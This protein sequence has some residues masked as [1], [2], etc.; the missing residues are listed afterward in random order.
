[1][2]RY[3]AF[4]EYEREM[5]SSHRAAS[6]DQGLTRLTAY[7]TNALLDAVGARRGVALLDVGTG[8]GLV[9]EGAAIRGCAVSGI[10]I[11][12]QMLDIARERVPDAEFREGSAEELPFS[13]ASFDAVV[14]N[15]V[16]LHL[17]YPDRLAFET[18]RVLRPGGRA[19]FTV[20]GEGN[21]NR[22]LGVFP[23]ALTRS[24]VAPPNDIPEGPLST[25]YANH[26]RF[27]DLLRNGGLS[28]V[29]VSDIE[30][31]FTVDPKRWWDDTVASTPRTGGLVSRQLPEVR[32]QLRLTYE[33]I[34][35]PYVGDDGLATFPV[36]AVLARGVR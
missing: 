14:G 11:S 7:T 31:T 21:R 2:S 9:A 5:W 3:D 16:V 10:D 19:A 36:V 30:W 20:W 32:E 4:N 34:V 15:F 23:D 28:E 17:G 27:A 6:Y 35:A 13:D 25:D 18:S 12:P 26:D 29:T 24:A 22:V 8:P 33:S 1:M